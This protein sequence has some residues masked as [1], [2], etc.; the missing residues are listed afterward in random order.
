MRSRRHRRHRPRSPSPARRPSPDRRRNL[1]RLARERD[2][3][4]RAED[5]VREAEERRF[6][7]ERDAEI[8]RRENDRVRERNIEQ[9]R[10]E[11]R[12]RR[13]QQEDLDR[14]EGE[15][16]FDDRLEREPRR[17]VGRGIPRE[18]REHQRPRAGFE[19]EDRGDAVILDAIR[20]GRMA[21][22]EEFFRPIRLA[23]RRAFGGGGERI[24]YEDELARPRWRWI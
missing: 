13:R 8:L 1:R 19:L 20:D 14:F 11:A 22:E 23:R 18:V 3:R 12:R 2:L 9:E 24:I 15:P 7:A 6:Q 21:R 5:D 10:R 17:R 4:H 16:L